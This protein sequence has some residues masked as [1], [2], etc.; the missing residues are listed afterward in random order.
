[1]VPLTRCFYFP[2]TSDSV[3]ESELSVVESLSCNLSGGQ[4]EK[5]QHGDHWDFVVSLLCPVPANG[6][7]PD[8]QRHSE[9]TEQGAIQYTAALKAS[10]GLMR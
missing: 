7:S 2:D 10:E 9:L 5:V 4:Y 1:M 3:P 6:Q 8:M